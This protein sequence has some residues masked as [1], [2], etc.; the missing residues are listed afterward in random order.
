MPE[1]PTH[2][3]VNAL[4]GGVFLP[5][6]GVERDMLVR[7]QPEG[8]LRNE[9]DAEHSWSVAMLAC[10]LAEHIDPTLD[11]GVVSQFAIVHDLVEVYAADTSCFASDEDLDA[12]EDN[13]AA[14]LAKLKTNF[15]NF[16]WLIETL[17]AYERQDTNEARYV[18]AIDKYIALV[19]R[20]MDGGEF[21]RNSGVTKEIF[22]S[23]LAVHREKAHKHPGVAD[24]YEQV[25]AVFDQHPEHFA[26]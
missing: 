19:T 4:V 20:F 25:R 11:V 6:Y 15:P 9:N 2:D 8:Q 14:A 13:E 24:Y 18:R 23:K 12:K 21:Y 26:Q 10:S 3:E 22:D 1:K 7:T 17:E 5:F 16:P